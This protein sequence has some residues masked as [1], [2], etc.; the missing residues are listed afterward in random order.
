[1]LI[2]GVAGALR[3]DEL[4]NLETTDIKDLD[5][6]FIVNIRA[7]KTNTKRVFT[8]V[9]NETKSLLCIIKK[10][11]NLR[12]ANTQHKRFFI[13]YN[14]NKCT[15]QPVG[16]NTFSKIPSI[17]ATFLNLQDPNLYTGHCFRRS[18]ASILSDSGADFSAIKRL[19]GWK[20]TSVAEGYIENSI[21][22]KDKVA[23]NILSTATS[24]TTHE[25]D[26]TT[27]LC[28]AIPNPLLAPSCSTTEV[29]RVLEETNININAQNNLTSN[30]TIPSINFTNCNIST[31]NLNIY[32]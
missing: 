14:N 10:Y 5:H 13:Y 2:F 1:M 24:T 16:I 9:E 30:L 20:S 11:I 19:G 22:N 25:D 8:I 31:F 26:A 4:L 23:K 12:P 28:S 18:S 17:I 3:K 7:N 27:P 15:R 6:K 21:S 29:N 32:K